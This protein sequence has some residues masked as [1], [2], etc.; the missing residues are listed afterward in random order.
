MV[1]NSLNWSPVTVPVLESTCTPTQPAL[2]TVL[3]LSEETVFPDCV[4]FMSN[5]GVKA[6]NPRLE[7]SVTVHL[8]DTKGLLLP[9]PLLPEP[10]EQLAR[11]RDRDRVN[12]NE[13]KRRIFAPNK[14]LYFV[15]DN[16]HL[17]WVFL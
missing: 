5:S 9:P 11:I 7:K 12:T 13:L 10:D 14:I 4:R 17:H 1:K 2:S 15:T 6:W 8:P 16:T 3:S